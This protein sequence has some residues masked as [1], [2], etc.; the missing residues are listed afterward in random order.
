MGFN[1]IILHLVLEIIKVKGQTKNTITVWTILF[2]LVLVWGSS[3]I[4]IK[5]GLE[6]FSA[7]E[8]GALRISIAFIFL[9]PFA[10]YRFRKINRRKLFII[11]II[12]LIGN[13]A[14]AFLFAL[15]Q[16]GIDSNLAGILNSMTPLFT[17]LIALAFFK[18]KSKWYN[19]LGV[20]IGLTG[21]IGLTSISGGNDFAF[22]IN[23][24]IYVFIATICYA[25]SVNLIKYY[26]KDIDVISITAFSFFFIGFPVVIFL[27][28]ATPF[29]SQ[30]ETNP[31]FWMGMMYIA[32][33]GIA[34]TALAL[35]IFNHLIKITNQVIASSVTYMIPIV[36]L[37]WGI[38]D[39]ERFEFTYV[40]W[41]V[42][43]LFGVYLVNRRK[44]SNSK[45][46]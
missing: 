45:F 36:A 38:I 25:T 14:P 21:A 40:I 42:L 39:G 5:K 15:A 29:I 32:I 31:D 26:L 43:I 27:L 23:Y 46:Q 44:I 10:I 33:L 41:V 9:I 28:T 30:I 6:V 11:T 24:A 18:F 37:M 20:F 4:L 3:F 19:I 2:I 7:V 1:K 35:F 16:T 34:G 8:V 17:L 12:G 13:M 22:N